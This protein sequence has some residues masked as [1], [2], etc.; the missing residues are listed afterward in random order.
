MMELMKEK[1]KQSELEKNKNQD[2]IQ[3]KGNK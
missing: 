2:S 3:D 1:R